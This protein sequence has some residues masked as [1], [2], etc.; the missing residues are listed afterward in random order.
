MVAFMVILVILSSDFVAIDQK[1][2][3]NFHLHFISTIPFP[4]AQQQHWKSLPDFC[5]IGD[6]FIRANSTTTWN[7]FTG[8]KYEWQTKKWC[9]YCPKYFWFWFIDVN[10][11]CIYVL[12]ATEKQIVHRFKWRMSFSVRRPCALEQIHIAIRYAP[13]TMRF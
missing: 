11:S 3:F 12:L 7:T 8:I 10:K 2:Y 5:T 13:V 4:W 9:I 1:L 6:Q